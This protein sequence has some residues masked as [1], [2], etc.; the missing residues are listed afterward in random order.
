LHIGEPKCGT[1]FLQDVL[2]QHRDDLAQH[3]VDLPGIDIS[4]HYRAAQDILGIDQASDDPGGTWAGAWDAL[5]KAAK[6]TSRKSAII[7]HELF[8]GADD[9]Q[10]ARAIASLAGVDVHVILTIRDLTGLLPAE[11]QETVKHKNVRTWRDWLGDVIDTPPRRRRPRAKWFWAAHDTVRVV[12]RWGTLVGADHVHVVTVPP[13]SS[14]PDL[15]WRRFAQAI[16]IGDI[17]IELSHTK[18]NASLGVVEVEMLRRLNERL[19]EAPLWFYARNVKGKLAHGTLAERGR[20]KR[21]AIPEDRHEWVRQQSTRRI[22][23]LRASGVE[24]IGDLQE[25]AAPKVFPSGVQP[26]DITDTEVLETALDTLGT[27]YLRQYSR[28][29][30]A[31]RLNRLARDA[32]PSVLRFTP[33]RRGRSAAWKLAHA[34]R[35]HRT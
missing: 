30:G 10:A 31:S 18:S 15:L 27:M 20:G 32:A 7:T 33:F 2:F 1:T 24:V 14:P 35:R 19:D 25:L 4:D 9:A 8:C 28:A 13:S 17:E 29:S 11:W 16:G 3:G 26:E 21:L 22:R 34:V 23:R 12:N 5:A 6:S